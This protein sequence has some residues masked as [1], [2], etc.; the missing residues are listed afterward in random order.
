MVTRIII[1][2]VSV[3]IFFGEYFI[4][5]LF[6]ECLSHDALITPQCLPFVCGVCLFPVVGRK[7]SWHDIVGLGG[8][9]QESSVSTQ[10]FVS[11]AFGFPYKIDRL[12]SINSE[13]PQL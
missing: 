10:H 12:V 5:N 8:E 6:Q 13:L 1:L 4:T 11:L 2:N 7:K 3:C 9:D